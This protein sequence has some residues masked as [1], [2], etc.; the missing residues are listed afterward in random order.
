[1]SDRIRRWAL[2]RPRVLIVAAAGS[3]RLRWLIE[4]EADRRGWVLAAAP[5][6]ADLLL[7]AGPLGPQLMAAVDVLWSQVP[8]PRHR[9][10]VTAQEVAAQLEAAAGALATPAA[11]AHDPV[12]PAALLSA[13]PH[14]HDSH[15]EP[16]AGHETHVMADN[17]AQPGHQMSGAGDGAHVQMG[18]GDMD[19][20][21][22]G[23]GELVHAEMDHGAM[24]HGGMDHGH[25]DHGGDVAGLAMAGTAPDRD[26]LELDELN[27]TLG[28]VLP[29]WPTGLIVRAGMQGDVL[30]RATVSWVDDTAP[31]TA[32]TDSGVD[33]RARAL[34]VLAQFLTVAGWPRAAR[35]AR[36]A[37]TDL[38][39]FDISR[40][41]RGSRHAVRLARAVSRSRTLAWSV[42]GLGTRPPDPLD[43]PPEGD[44]WERVRRWCALAAGADVA[45]HPAPVISPTE[46]A[47]LLAGA[48]LAA[49]RL[50]TASTQIAQPSMTREA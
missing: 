8:G 22:M 46:L 4:A 6:E 21:H 32:T 7:T 28:P 44:V 37:R 2:A 15:T 12:D 48:E 27:I 26:G 25:M 23:H 36:A 39:G 9:A 20:G 3:D 45:E 35:Q 5:A 10:A 1:M 18:H 49:A 33:E 11:Y 19:D 43:D 31:A 30:T 50:I 13:M 47:E 42:R 38:A 34:D 40:A 41:E 29:A 17:D 16:D 14:V 24:G